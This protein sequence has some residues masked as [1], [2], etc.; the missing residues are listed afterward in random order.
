MKNPSKSWLA[1]AVLGTAVLLGVTACGGSSSSESSSQAP[2]SE[3]AATPATPS[4]STSAEDGGTD[5]PCAGVTIDKIG[6]SPLTAKFDYFQFTIQGMEEAAAK[7]GAEVIVDDPNNDAGKQV[8]GIENL[9]AAGAGAV[10]VVSI[11][12]NAVKTAV[13]AAKDAGAFVISQV[14]TFEG[15]DVYVGLPESEFGRLQGSGAGAALK[16]V[17]PDKETYKVAILNADSLGSGL[18]DRKAGLISG[19]EEN[20]TNYE[21][22]ADVEAYAEE[23]ALS[24][25]ENILQANPD[26]DLILTV[27]DPGS[28]GARAAVE[29][30]GLTL[31]TDVMVGGLGIDKRVLQGVLSGD[32]PQSVSPEPV[33]TGVAIVDAAF[34]LSAGRSVEKDIQIPPVLITKENAQQY[35]DLL[36]PNG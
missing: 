18:L 26:L 31:N 30:A 36:Y 16:Q 3:S 35:L 13:A 25:V 15:A 4:T 14:S 10:G 17:K 9:V 5:D 27:N 8:T 12:P 2:A 20:I 11:D 24:A 32:F 33:A 34:A 28:L 21:I 1:A 19:L 22:V 6:Y 29:G 7:C 23:T